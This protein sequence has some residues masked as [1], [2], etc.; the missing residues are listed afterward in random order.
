MKAPSTFTDRHPAAGFMKPMAVGVVLFNLLVVTATL[1]LLYES[2]TQYDER[3]AGETSNLA[4][5]LEQYL[6]G[7]VG[8]LDLALQSVA[9]EAQMQLAAGAIDGAALNGFITR[10]F[11]RQ[12]DLDSL[13]VTDVQGNILYGIGVNPSSRVIVADR[14]YFIRLRDDP[15]EGLVFSKPVLGRI[16][17][18]WVVI[19]ARRIKR[20]DGSFGGVVYAPIA[21]E[22]FQKI[23]S[24]I[25]IGENGAITLRDVDLSIIARF[26][27]P[28]GTGSSI[29][30][31][32]ASREFQQLMQAG[33]VAGTYTVRAGYDQVERVYSYRKIGRYPL[34]IIVGLAN[35]DYLGP[36]RGEAIERVTYAGLF[37]AIS[38]IWAWMFY[39]GWARRAFADRLEHQVQERTVQLRAMAT[40]LTMVEERERQTLAQDLHDG[41]GQTLA[42]AKLKLSALEPPHEDCLFPEELKQEITAIEALIDDA[43]K[44][45]RSL[46]LQL[47]PP[48]LRDLGLGASLEWL[49]DEMHRSYGLRVN[50]HLGDLARPLDENVLNLVF[51]ATRELLINV[52]RHAFVDSADVTA[53]YEEDHLVI[54]VT[55]S[56][57]GFDAQ[58]GS[59]PSAK[60]GF[61]LFSVRERIHFIG[62]DVQIDTS[63][64]DGTIVVLM[65]PLKVKYQE[66]RT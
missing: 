52:A 12:S 32:A 56:G 23:F 51:R 31:K 19:L 49:A 6:D 64:G 18:K 34:V 44:T 40:E 42:I 58:Q 1:L 22:H 11:E 59:M 10:Q 57:A 46:S 33:S 20:P 17:G 8:K 5:V 16:S 21:V 29:G 9:D 43:N 26:P 54:S 28:S 61:G 30:S 55:D 38:I 39:R 7:A 27:E 14:D 48:V 65:V 60:G 2:R 62:G 4:R 37:A 3:A 66:T 41:L 36:W 47:S 35:K 13:R 25:A 50:L 63:P 15:S 53:T 24:T 45:V